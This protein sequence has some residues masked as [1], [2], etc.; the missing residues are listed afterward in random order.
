MHEVCTAATDED[1]NVAEVIFYERPVPLNRADHRDLRIRPMP[2]VGFASK[3]HSVPLTGVEFIQAA[4]DFP[5]LFAGNSEADAGP[6][7]LLG[8]RES[9]NLMVDEDGTW[10][11]GAYIPAFIRRYPFVLAEKPE[12]QEGDDFTVFLDEAYA[13]FNKDEGDRLFNED[14]SDTEM[15]QNAVRFLGEFQ[16][17]VKHT[18]ALMARLRELELLEA[19]SIRI[20]SSQEGSKNLVLNGLYVVNEEKLQK[21][22]AD[23]VHDMF[24]KGQLAWVMAHLMSLGNIERLVARLNKHTAS[25]M[26]QAADTASTSTVN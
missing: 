23:V 3:A 2:G 11:Q 16:D 9:E 25:E 19:R 6:M 24:K 1:L 21:L 20:E 22:D 7:A 18:Q 10:E 15:L 8:L 17:Q 14:G 12:G 26:E 4:R 13:G 5:I